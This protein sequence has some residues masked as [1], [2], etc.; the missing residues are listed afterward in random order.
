MVV[1]SLVYTSHAV[2]PFT[3]DELVELL[4]LAREKN[5]RLGITGLLL[6]REGAFM[7]AL[8]GDE[9]VVRELYASIR[10]D[11]RHHLVLTLVAMP[12]ATRQFQDWSM[13]F[14]NLDQA[15]AGTVTGSNPAPRV[16]TAQDE[17][18]WRASV[19]MSLLATF[20]QQ[21]ED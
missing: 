1:F 18:S 4:R 19:A 15:G 17:V 9:A 11:P 10:Q 14:S 20:Q 5:A 6:Y 12:V 13:G 16:P 21:P 2:Q 8:E 7:Q 3:A